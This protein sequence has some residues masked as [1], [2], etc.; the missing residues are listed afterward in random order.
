VTLPS[1]ESRSSCWATSDTAGSISFLESP[2]RR[3]RLL[4]GP[5]A[6]RD[7]RPSPGGRLSR[8]RATGT[9]LA[10]TIR[11]GEARCSCQDQSPM[12][13]QRPR[14]RDQR[15]RAPSAS[16]RGRLAA[17]A[18]GRATASAA[19]AH[20]AAQDQRT[21]PSQGRSERPSASPE[22]GELERAGHDVE[23]TRSRFPPRSPSSSPCAQ[24][25]W[26]AR[27]LR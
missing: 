19:L 14:E 23:A 27:L 3:D 2:V 5:R 9:A 22:L 4:E 12:A 26:L 1:A 18:D 20:A 10:R 15:N 16:P 24:L 13:R 25:T 8:S 11:G 7:R 6:Q 21:E 17:R